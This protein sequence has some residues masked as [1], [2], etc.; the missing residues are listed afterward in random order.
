[1]TRAVTAMDGDLRTALLST[2]SLASHSHRAAS[3][4]P[5]PR[6]SPQERPRL[7]SLR[8]RP[9]ARQ[10]S[11]SALTART[12]AGTASTISTMASATTVGRARRRTRMTSLPR[13]VSTDTTFPTAGRGS[14]RIL[15][16]ATS[17]RRLRRRLRRRRRLHPRCHRHPHPP[18]PSPPSR[19]LRPTDELASP[20]CPPSTRRSPSP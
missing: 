1:M 14:A 4:P 3:S 5:A 17:R 12:Q 9:R 7:R 15:S 18:P 6:R 11:R 8:R 2:S 13:S 20:R 10:P 16:P 19:R